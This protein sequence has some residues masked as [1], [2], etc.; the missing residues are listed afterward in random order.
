MEKQGRI[1]ASTTN[2]K[3]QAEKSELEEALAKGDSLIKD[4]ES[5]ARKVEMEKKE[6][7][8]QVSD[9]ARKLQEEEEAAMS[10]SNA[11]KK[12]EAEVKRGK[13]DVENMDFRWRL[14]GKKAFYLDSE[15]RVLKMFQMGFSSEGVN[16]KLPKMAQVIMTRGAVKKL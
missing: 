2:E 1:K 9:L 16:N 10:I 8:R 12:L 4:M 11:V 6:V 15:K 14:L 7:D 13:E 3:L 5:K